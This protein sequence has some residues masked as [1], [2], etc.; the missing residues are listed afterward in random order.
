MTIKIRKYKKGD[1]KQILNL[2]R[3]V[4]TH[5]WNRRNLKNWYWKYKGNN[6]FGNS[7]VWVAM[8]KKKVV[9]T[10]SIIP[11]DYIVKGKILKG[12][13]SI[14]MIVHPEYQNKGLIKF[15]ADKLF[16]EAKLNKI[17]FVYGYPNENAYQIHKV[18]FSYKDISKQ[19]LYFKKIN[20][21]IKISL[22]NKFEINEV[23]KFINKD[24]FFLKRVS[25][26]RKICLKR[27]VEFLNWRYFD[28]PDYKYKVFKF[29]KNKDL[30]AYVVLKVYKE[31]K[32]LRG[33]VIDLFYDKKANIFNEIME[34]S[35]KFFAKNNCN[36]LTLWLQGDESAI[37]KLKKLGFKTLN[38]RPM[39]CKF[40]DLKRSE[41][42]ELNKKDWYFTMGDT[43]EIY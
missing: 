25:K 43:L 8:N 35:I 38:S 20:K 41:I 3:L 42:S 39:I 32:I 40:I 36:E 22:E 15:V 9:A 10:F 6:P 13:C 23:K 4:E 17:K 33:H 27:T 34:F 19:K 24:D 5:P 29:F 26:Q 21:K 30:I 31:N 28:R 2:D 37:K 16:D 11:L 14:A 12:S 1:E 7:L 18:F